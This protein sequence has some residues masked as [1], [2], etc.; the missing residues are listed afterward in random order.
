MSGNAAE[1]DFL[2]EELLQTGDGSITAWH[3]EYKEHYH[4]RQGA[5]SE[6]ETKFIRPTRLAERL[7]T[8]AQRLLD[9]GFGLGGNAFAAI[10]CA[11]QTAGYHLH[12]DSLENDQEALRRARLSS[13]DNEE[14]GWLE[15]LQNHNV[16]ELPEA[17]LRLHALDFR[18]ADRV[19]ETGS[20]DLFFHDP[21]SPMK[22]PQGWTLELFQLYG[23]LAATDAV[24]ATYSQAWAVRSALQLSGWHVQEV[25][26]SNE[27]RSSTL[28][29]RETVDEPITVPEGVKQVPYRDPQLGDSAI[30]ILR[31][32]QAEIAAQQ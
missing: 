32:R 30:T 14:R 10:R 22:N 11:Q 29:S 16:L 6:A 12:I 23:R 4:S 25:D 9:I 5:R 20:I 1:D 31:R 26:G 17:T 8:R 21:F 13:Q 3:P 15:Q 2:P 18:Q 7:Q 19:A 27:H 24:L 28:A